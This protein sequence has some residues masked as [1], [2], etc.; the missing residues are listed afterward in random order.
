MDDSSF[1]GKGFLKLGIYIKIS[2][3]KNLFKV[4]F[5]NILFQ[6]YYISICNVKDLLKYY[7]M[8]SYIGIIFTRII[9]KL[10]AS[11]ELS[12]FYFCKTDIGIFLM[13]ACMNIIEYQ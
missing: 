10:W 13:L 6:N 5:R 11:I 7:V 9:L 2:L 3:F 12:V 1:T 8:I 4:Q